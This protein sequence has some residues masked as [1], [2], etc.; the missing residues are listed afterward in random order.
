MGGART[1]RE[2]PVRPPRSVRPPG[3]PT[4]PHR[5]TP[6]EGLGSGASAVPRGTPGHPG[7]LRAGT[8]DGRQAEALSP[9]G[10]NHARSVSKETW[11]LLPSGST[12]S[13]NG[14]GSTQTIVPYSVSI[15]YSTVSP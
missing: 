7:V 12:S 2:P 11:T 10:S 6:V 5:T 1:A 13:A 9:A 3:L 14:S 15:S 8:A 4:Q